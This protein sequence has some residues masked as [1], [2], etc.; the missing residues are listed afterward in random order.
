M[1]WSKLRRMNLQ[2]HEPFIILYFYFNL[3]F[4]NAFM[5]CIWIVLEFVYIQS[6]FEFTEFKIQR[7]QKDTKWK[8]FSLHTGL[9]PVSAS[10][11]WCRTFYCIQTSVCMY[12]CRVLP[13]TFFFAW[14]HMISTA[15]HLVPLLTT[16]ASAL[17]AGHNS[18]LASVKRFLW[19]QI[20]VF[21]V[22]KCY[23]SNNFIFRHNQ[24]T[25]EK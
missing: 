7:T 16:P 12:T 25:R 3:Y 11:V 19:K 2:I 18:L 15:G 10:C 4:L 14:M 21:K 20:F 22:Y 5:Y 6:V 17:P 13:F 8:V 9:L 23:N 1:V 24:G